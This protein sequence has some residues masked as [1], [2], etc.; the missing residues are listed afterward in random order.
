MRRS[1]FLLITLPG[2]LGKKP[3]SMYATTASV[4]TCSMRTS[5]SACFKGCI[6][7]RNSKAPGSVSRLYAGSS[8]GMVAGRGPKEPLDRVRR[9]T[10]A[11][12]RLHQQVIREIKKELHEDSDTNVAP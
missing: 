9:F 7:L 11:C 8:V 2:A 6:P 4:S 12:H 3:F 5:S 10:A 1:R